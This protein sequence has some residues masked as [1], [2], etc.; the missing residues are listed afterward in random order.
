[1]P[2]STTTLAHPI[3]NVS[4]LGEAPAQQL[5]CQPRSKIL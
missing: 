3:R 5:L 2:I 4:W 1:L